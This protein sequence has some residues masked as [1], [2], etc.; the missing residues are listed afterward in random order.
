MVTYNFELLKVT[1][2]PIYQDFHSCLLLKILV[3]TTRKTEIL[4]DSVKEVVQKCMFIYHNQ[5]AVQ[6]LYVNIVYIP[7]EKCR[8][9][10][11]FGNNS[12]NLKLR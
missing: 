8:K 2:Y 5:N 6:Y 12:N 11:D 9:V 10:Q 4:L 3:N 7:L 1:S